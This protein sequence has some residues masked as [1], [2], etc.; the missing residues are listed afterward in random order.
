MDYNEPV[1]GVI[2]FI[3]A[4]NKETPKHKVRYEVTVN[5]NKKE[6]PPGRLFSTKED[7]VNSDFL[8]KL[9]EIERRLPEI[10]AAFKTI[11]DPMQRKMTVLK[12]KQIY[13]QLEK[14]A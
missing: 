14:L 9:N 11:K 5:G 8:F 13:S 12:V 7:C 1:Q 2:S 4:F 6:V 10:E 3:P